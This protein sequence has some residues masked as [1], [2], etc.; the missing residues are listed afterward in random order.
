MQFGGHSFFTLAQ[1]VQVATLLADPVGIVVA[2]LPIV[3]WRMAELPVG[4]AIVDPRFGPVA[5][6]LQMKL[7]NQTALIAGIGNQ[8]GDRFQQFPAGNP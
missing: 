1:R 2:F 8:L 3:T 7:A 6:A 4:K 5:G